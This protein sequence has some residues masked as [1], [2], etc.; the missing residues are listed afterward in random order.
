MGIMLMGLSTGFYY[1]A[2]KE[3]RENPRS[4]WLFC[5]HAIFCIG[6]FM[7]LYFVI[8]LILK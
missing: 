2:K 5:C 1:D 3:K 7:D 4:N 8:G 6:V